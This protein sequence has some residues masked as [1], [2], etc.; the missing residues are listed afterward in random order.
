M[1]LFE[2]LR[3]RNV[4]RVAA[5]YVVVSWLVVQTANTLVNI[6]QLP[7]AITQTIL[8]LFILGFIPV[9]FFAWAFE[10]TPE[11]I[12]KEKDV[13]RNDAASYLAAKKLNILTL[14]SVVLAV[15]LFVYQ[16]VNF[17]KPDKPNITTLTI[18]KSVAVLPF[19][20]LSTEEDDT[21][22]GKGL[23]EELLNALAQFPDLKVAA[24]TSAFSFDGKDIDLR[25]V[26][27][28][29]GV[30]NVL[31]GSIRRSGN[32]L[33]ITAQLIRTMDGFHLWSETYERELT[34][35]FQ[36]QDDI[37]NE[38]SRVMQFQ[39]GVGAGSGRAS[40]QNIDPHAY[41]QYMRGLD[42]WWRRDNDQNRTN[43]IIAFQNATELDNNFADAWA[44]YATSLALTGSVNIPG[45]SSD[46]YKSVIQST[47]DRALALDPK[48]IKA[49]AASVHYYSYKN[50]DYQ[51]AQYHLT[52]SLEI[53]PSSA[54]T[55]YSASNFY[56]LTGNLEKALQANTRAVALDPLNKT[57][58]RSKFELLSIMG[59]FDEGVLIVESFVNC[60]PPN[61]TLEHFIAGATITASANIASSLDVLLKRREQWKHNLKAI[62]PLPPAA[63]AFTEFMINYYKFVFQESDK[64]GDDY[65]KNLDH[66]G[67]LF[68]QNAALSASVFA[69][70]GQN[71]IA[72]DI[73][74]QAYQNGYLFNSLQSIFV[75]TQGRWEMP[76]SLRRDPRYH[77]FWNQPELLDMAEMRRANGQAAGLPLP[78]DG[79]DE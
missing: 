59:R 29:L 79:S 20:A 62:E 11:G 43:A 8:L 31:E 69:Q 18:E 19:V 67:W 4:F 27:E 70:M 34:D 55:Q 3:K 35:I 63:V 6:L 48:N 30:A 45:V 66:S 52:K 5:A 60:K 39:L 68:K 32:K 2:E 1:S 21:Y 54:L 42:L 40:K 24:R 10:I 75:F 25:T 57:I 61:C 33:R 41:D 78:I 73:L 49:H 76:E 77:E 58:N 9:V 7:P 36:I 14:V 22:F 23:A 64:I 51:K 56:A 46:Q 13:I 53:A 72:L 16:Q 47:L 26:G 50:I 17:S 65:W 74:D 44:S 38:L 37:V 12:K 15:T 28:T 71:N